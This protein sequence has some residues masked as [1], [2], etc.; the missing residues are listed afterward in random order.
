VWSGGT[1]LLDLLLLL[2]VE[3]HGGLGF[4]RL[5]VKWGWFEGSDPRRNRVR[6]KRF[7]WG[8]IAFLL[9]LGILSLTAYMKIGIAHADKVGERYRP[10]VTI[11]TPYQG[12]QP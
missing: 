4:Y 2:A 8:L 5:A 3:F 11:Q 7:V 1:W 9:L 12:V 10:P 6:L